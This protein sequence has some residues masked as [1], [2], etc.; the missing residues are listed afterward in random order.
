MRRKR[1]RTR[2]CPQDQHACCR[3]TRR[4]RNFCCS[5][6]KSQH[7]MCTTCFDLLPVL[8]GNR[9]PAGL[10]EKFLAEDM[11]RNHHREQ[12]LDRCIYWS[13]RLASR[14]HHDVLVIITDSLNRTKLPWPAWDVERTPHRS[15]HMHRPRKRV[16]R[17]NCSPLAH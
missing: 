12:F 4:G 8:R 11:L 5:A 2:T 7:S 1:E 9:G 10:Q 16:D 15:E 17:S 13:W 6:R 3:G 14:M